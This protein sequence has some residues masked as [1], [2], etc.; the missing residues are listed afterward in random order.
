MEII[1][2]QWVFYLFLILFILLIVFFVYLLM[3]KAR[4]N[5]KREQV[6]NYKESIQESFMQYMYLQDESLRISPKNSVQIIAVEELLLGLVKVVNGEE[7]LEFIRR[8]AKKEFGNVYRNQLKHRRWSVRMNALYAIEELHMVSLLD[9]VLKVLDK[10]RVTIAEESQILRMLVLFQHPKYEQYLLSN[11]YKRSEFTY[12]SLL[13]MM[14]A[15]QFERFVVR[16]KEHKEPIQLAIIDVIGINRKIEQLSLLESQLYSTSDEARIR[17]LKA[18]HQ[19]SYVSE[20]S[21]LVKHVKSDLW[22]ERM[23]AAKLLSKVQGEGALL[24]LEELLN[25]RSF[26]VRSNAAQAIT[27][28]PNGY[29]RLRMISAET[30]DLFARDMANE[31][32]EKGGER[33]V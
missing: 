9:D 23:M 10:K 12:R 17:A 22:E 5:R 7:L 6:E 25:D 18:L 30:Q 33:S 11:R 19:L 16:F 27:Q 20:T 14:N 15:E 8:Y 4:V 3:K 1:K 32:L 31:W 26:L 21:R 2:I 24:L 29:E 28:A 13:G